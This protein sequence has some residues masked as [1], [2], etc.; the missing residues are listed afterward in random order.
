MGING[1][2][3]SSKL[4]TTGTFSNPGQCL[5]MMCSSRGF[6]GFLLP[7]VRDTVLGPVSAK[8]HMQ[9]DLTVLKRRVISMK[10]VFLRCHISCSCPQCCLCRLAW[11]LFLLSA[12]V[13]SAYG[14][15]GWGQWKKQNDEEQEDFYLSTF[16]QGPKQAMNTTGFIAAVISVML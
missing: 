16:P 8:A 1:W 7:S 2:G 11:L 6:Y 15:S 10:N 3:I 4:N 14:I 13:P 5:C 12:L 9:V